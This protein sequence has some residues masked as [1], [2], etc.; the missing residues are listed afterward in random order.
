MKVEFGDCKVEA[1]VVSVVGKFTVKLEEI[2]NLAMIGNYDTQSLISKAINAAADEIARSY[3][4]QYKM[5]I[6]NAI[7]LKEIT[8]AI[9]LKIV[10]G[11]S[12]G[13]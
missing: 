1:D 9:Q 3:L 5:Q 7:S 13:H 12:L 10:E 8:D 4:A 2:E 11:F 6:A